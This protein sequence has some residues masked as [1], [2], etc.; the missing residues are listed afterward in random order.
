MGKFLARK[1]FLEELTEKLREKYG[2]K[3]REDRDPRQYYKLSGK[4]KRAFSPG[5]KRAQGDERGG[6]LRLSKPPVRGGTDGCTLSFMGLPCPNLFTGGRDERPFRVLNL[7]PS[8]R[9]E[10]AVEVFAESR[11]DLFFADRKMKNLTGA[12]LRRTPE[13][14]LLFLSPLSLC[15]TSLTFLF[16][17]IFFAE[18]NVTRILRKNLTERQP[19]ARGA[20]LRYIA[21]F[22]PSLPRWGK[23]PVPELRIS[24]NNRSFGRQ[25]RTGQGACVKSD[26]SVRQ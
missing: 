12:G 20:L 11:K 8:P 18:K 9:L 1:A 7:S 10:K 6:R 15:D 24:R 26:G 22:P 4:D 25:S 16:R 2:E 5:R 14:G 17:Y 21:V 23:V 19:R 13:R 3:A